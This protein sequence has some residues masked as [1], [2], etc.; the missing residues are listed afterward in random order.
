[1]FDGFRKIMQTPVKMMIF[2]DP[3]QRQA[4]YRN[5]NEAISLYQ[6]GRSVAK[7]HPGKGYDARPGFRQ[8]R[9]FG[10]AEQDKAQDPATSPAHDD[11]KNDAIENIL[12]QP[13]PGP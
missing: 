12:K 13:V 5:S 8:D 9:P 1:M 10:N 2:L 11:T 4:K 6:F 7:Q 3:A